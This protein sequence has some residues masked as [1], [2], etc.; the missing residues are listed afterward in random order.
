M[1]LMPTQS[2]KTGSKSVIIPDVFLQDSSQTDDRG[3]ASLS[4]TTPSLL[5]YYHRNT[6]SA[7]VAVTLAPMTLG[8][9]ATGGFK[10]VDP[11][12]MPGVYSFC[13]PDAAFAAGAQSVT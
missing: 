6:A 11:T 3:L 10:E 5:C 4:N 1:I 2:V 8:T 12:N 9:W 13:P 7:A